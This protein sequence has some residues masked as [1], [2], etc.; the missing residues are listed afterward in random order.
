MS[1]SRTRKLG[2][3]CRIYK[4]ASNEILAIDTIEP[5]VD[6]ST[7]T[8]TN[9]YHRSV[10]SISVSRSTL[11]LTLGASR[12]ISVVQVIG[13][14]SSIEENS[15]DYLI[16]TWAASSSNENDVVFSLEPKVAKIGDTV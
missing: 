14:F 15:G 2:Q 6:V 5:V 7:L 11:Y 10:S 9:T 8:T 13:D 3:L 16:V 4:N 1:S 12:I